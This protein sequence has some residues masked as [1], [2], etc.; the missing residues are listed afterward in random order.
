MTHNKKFLILDNNNNDI[1][2]I[3]KNNNSLILNMDYGDNSFLDILRY[4]GLFETFEYLNE[5]I[6]FEHK[7]VKS[8]T[9]ILFN[10]NNEKI[11]FITSKYE[12]IICY[13]SNNKILLV[14]YIKNKSESFDIKQLYYPY[15]M[16]YDKIN[17]KKL[18]IPLFINTDNNLINIYKFEFTDS[19]DFN[20]IKQI[21]HLIYS[22]E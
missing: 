12:N 21:K 9:N 7:I 2:K 18:I 6:L 19:N 4:A 16:L 14:Y 17:N 3:N 10:I 1:I 13:E 20:S 22:L 11:N 5:S 15:K 8:N